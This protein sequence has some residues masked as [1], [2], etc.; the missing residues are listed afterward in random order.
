MEVRVTP[1]VHIIVALAWAVGVF[2]PGGMPRVEDL[3]HSCCAV[4]LLLE[5]LGNGREVAANISPVRV[6]VPD[7]GGV[8]VPTG[9]DGSASG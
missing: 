9:E 4:P 1:A 8:R 5:E 6:E 2:C 7:A 3:T